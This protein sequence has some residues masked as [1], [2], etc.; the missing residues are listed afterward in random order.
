MKLNYKRVICVGFAFFLITAFWQAYDKTIPLILTYKFNMNQTLSG[1][2]MA[3]DNVLAVFLLPLFGVLSDKT[4]SRLGKRTVF[5]LF[6]TILAVV[7]FVFL[8]LIGNVWLFIAV[9]LVT[10]LSMATFRS[11][12]VALMPDVTCKPL[13]SKGNAIINLVGTVGGLIVLGVG[14]VIKVG[15]ETMNNLMPYYIVVCGVILLGLIIFLLTVKEKKWAE[16][17]KLD[18]E[19]YF[20]EQEEKEDS[21]ETRKLSKPELRSLLLIL[22]SVALWFMG[23]NAITSKYSLYADK[24]LHQSYDLTLLIAQGAAII[25]YLPVGMLA[26]KIGRKKTILAGVVMLALAFFFAIFITADSSPLIMYVL[27]ALAGIG[28]AT[29]NVNSFPM[30]VELAKDSNVGKYTGWYYTAS[31]SAQVI[32]PILSGAIMDLAQN[33]LPLFPYACICVSLAFITMI[34]VKHGDSKPIKKNSVLENFNV[35]D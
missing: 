29:I 6:G 25:S 20:P 33:M 21:G 27:F 7:S 28:W 16:Q 2:I 12:A 3:F 15:E 13:R 1:L 24:V 34:L 22:G 14:L 10:L 23:Y 4:N 35:D 17:M 26:T 5:I 30:V 11:P 19:K 32:T 31:M 18:T 8:P 9:L